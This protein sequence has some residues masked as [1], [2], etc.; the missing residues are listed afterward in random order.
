ML[1]YDTIQSEFVRDEIRRGSFDDLEHRQH[2]NELSWI[3]WYTT[4]WDRGSSFGQA[5]TNGK[6]AALYP[7]EFDIVRRELGEETRSEAIPDH[8]IHRGDD[9]SEER[10]LARTGYR[11]SVLE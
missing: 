8:K 7:E 2:V 10:H 5:V 3:E 4:D 9:D 11:K 1:P 6:L